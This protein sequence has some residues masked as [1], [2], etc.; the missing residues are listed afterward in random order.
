MAEAE[1]FYRRAFESSA[2]IGD[3]LGVASTQWNLAALYWER[4]D[5]LNAADEMIQ[6]LATRT[7]I[8]SVADVASDL[9]VARR[10]W[11]ALDHTQRESILA[12]GQPE[13]RTIRVLLDQASDGT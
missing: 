1:E 3:R 2:R 11:R 4:G 12:S 7:Q 6:S 8:G 9:V 13:I 10:L 5:R